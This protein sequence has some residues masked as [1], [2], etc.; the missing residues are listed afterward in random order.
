MKKYSKASVKNL[1]HPVCVE[2][3]AAI[4]MYGI[5][6]RPT[7]KGFTTSGQRKEL[8]AYCKKRGLAIVAGYDDKKTDGRRSWRRLIQDAKSG[9]FDTVAVVSICRLGRSKSDFI[10]RSQELWK[11]GV[12]LVSV[13][14]EMSG[15]GT[16]LGILAYPN[17]RVRKLRGLW[18]SAKS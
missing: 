12:Q 1:S 9:Q 4:Y 14:C 10:E 6:A 16:H 13:K 3:K 15:G 5:K 17:E 8:E 2:Q 11:L 18:R 7:G